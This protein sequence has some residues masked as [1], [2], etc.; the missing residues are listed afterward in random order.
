MGG[1]EVIGKKNS[2]FIFHKQRR[3]LQ[4]V[5]NI[6]KITLLPHNFYELTNLKKSFIFVLNR[7]HNNFVILDQT[8]V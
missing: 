6:F 5:K 2:K 8:K 1:G 7:K 4:L 3:A